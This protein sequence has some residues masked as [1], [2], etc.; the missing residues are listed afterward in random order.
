MQ[1]AS[2][3]SGSEGNALVVRLPGA[4]HARGEFLLIDC[5]FAPR[6]L[7]R[8]LDRLALSPAGLRGIVVTHEH[9]DHVGGS[10]KVA[11]RQ[12]CPVYLTHGTRMAVTHRAGFDPQW[13]RTITPDEPFEVEG[14]ELT[15]VPVP[16][17]AREPVQFV[18]DDG[19]SRLGVLTDIGCSTNHV[20][21][22]MSALTAMVLEC[23]HDRDMLAASRYPLPLKRRISGPWGHLENDAAADILR[24]IQQ[25]R[26]RTVVAAHLSQENNRPELACQALARAIGANNQDIRVADQAT[27]IA[28]ING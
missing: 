6:E 11:A 23:N 14:L 20:E 28:W 25:S 7:A 18:V 9:G 5:G 22:S 26:L 10:F 21:A 4:A 2:L 16:H 3:G 13:C 24:R 19:V 12:R 27:G 8:R 15:P 1:F 17:D